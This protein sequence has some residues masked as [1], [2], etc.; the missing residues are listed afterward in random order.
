MKKRISNIILGFIIL[1][2]LLLFFSSQWVITTFGGVTTEEI[3]FNLSVPQV[4]ANTKVIIDFIFNTIV[5]S[6]FLSYILYVI[7][8]KDKNIALEVDIKFKKIHFKKEIFP[9]NNLFKFFIVLLGFCFSFYYSF[10][11]TGLF[12]YIENQRKISNL[13]EEEYVEPLDTSI[14]FDNEKRNLIYIFAESMETSYT[15]LENGGT[16]KYNLIDGL[17]QLSNS[18]IT[19]SNSEK[20]G[21]LLEVPGTTWTVAGMVSQTSGL[22]LKMNVAG[23]FYR[24]YKTFLPSAYTLGDVLNE[25][26]YNQEI[27]MG[28][29]ASYA[30][31]KNYFKSHGN[32]KIYDLNTAIKNGKMTRDDIVWWGFDDRMLFEIAKEEA[33]KLAAE[34][35][36]FNLTLLTADTHAEDGYL[37]DECDIKYDEKYSN[38]ISCSSDLILEFVKWVQLQDFYE[39]TTIII[40]GD[41]LSM[42][43]DFFNGMDPSL[44]RTIYNVFINSAVSTEDYKNRTI[45]SMDLYPTTLAAMGASIE[46]DRLGLGTNLFSD[47]PTIAEL[48]GIDTFRDELEKKSVFYN[49]RFLK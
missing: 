1:I 49:E 36:S 7:I 17:T 46:G 37:S 5:L 43:Y 19:F 18:Y 24:K 15:T 6:I 42:D 25:N 34:G 23:S 11:K 20:L 33:L 26:G 41:H 28:S 10:N 47:K 4:G 40:V 45:T 44:V 39:N 48:Y 29:E 21:G 30:G 12:E 38:V 13:F 16:Q 32:Y 35:S 31:R 8:V 2:T 22:P 14:T 9:F 3:I 27:I